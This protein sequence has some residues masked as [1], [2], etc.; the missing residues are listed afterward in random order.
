[1]NQVRLY[2]GSQYRVEDMSHITLLF[3]FWGP[4]L[5]DT[6]PYIKNAVMQHLYD[7]K[8]FVLVEHAADADFVVV[9]HSYERYKRK[10]P[11]K[12]AQLKAEAR[13]AHKLI[14]ADASS[15]VEH[16]IL[17]E[18]IV[19]FRQSQYRYTQKDNEITIPLSAEDLLESYY[20]GVL[21]IRHKHVVPSI[22]FMGWARLPLARHIKTKIKELPKLFYSVFNSDFSA[23]QRGVFL[24][25]RALK[26]L[27]NNTAIDSRF[28]IRDSYSGH[29]ETL[30]GSVEEKRKQFVS[31]IFDADY[32]L[33]VRGDG[34]SSIRFYEALSLGRIPLLLDTACVFP[35]EDKI[36][37][38][39]FCVF[40]DH[41]DLA[42]IDERLIQ[43]HAACSPEKFEQMQR[44]A[45]E[46]FCVYLRNDVFYQ[47]VAEKLRSFLVR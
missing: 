17:D 23:E 25:Q 24:R 33:C 46:I 1:M 9:P 11:E 43:F 31:N 40:V 44:R 14:L 41:K 15:D 20:G 7:G 8:D 34:N 39:E 32:A 36:D 21:T 6:M 22:S 28:L 18:D 37:Y 12:L 30:Q 3:P 26:I 16:P 42:H 45:R 5:R 19:V 10:Y 2:V 35:L 29:I 47:H 38:K 13:A 27:K 4:I